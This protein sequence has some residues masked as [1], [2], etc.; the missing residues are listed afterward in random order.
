MAEVVGRHE[1]EMRG[2]LV[3]VDKGD[4]TALEHG[5]DDV[6]ARHPLAQQEQPRGAFSSCSGST[7]PHPPSAWS[8]PAAA[9]HFV[10]YVHCV[11]L[12]HTPTTTT[13]PPVLP[14]TSTT[15]KRSSEKR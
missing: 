2:G 14:A 13:A 1:A 12:P 6:L 8:S 3:R 7:L 15:S 5:L 9:T 4:A 11:G 10:A